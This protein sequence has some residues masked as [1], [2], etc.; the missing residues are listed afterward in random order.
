MKA[1]GAFR[2]GTGWTIANLDTSHSDL[3]LFKSRY[4][5]DHLAESDE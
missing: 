4:H 2:A 1:P 3:A 5:D